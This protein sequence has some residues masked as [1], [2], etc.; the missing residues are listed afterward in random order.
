M[1][2]QFAQMDHAHGHRR[3]NRGTDFL[4]MPTRDPP[5]AIVGVHALLADARLNQLTRTDPVCRLSERRRERPMMDEDRTLLSRNDCTAPM[6]KDP[7]ATRNGRADSRSHHALTGYSR[8]GIH[9]TT[10]FADE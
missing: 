10:H 3:E 9:D 6:T 7:Q 5:A 8:R 2:A 4:R 1:F